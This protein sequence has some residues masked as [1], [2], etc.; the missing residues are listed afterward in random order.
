MVVKIVSG[1]VLAGGLILLLFFGGIFN[2][3]SDK[4][5]DVGVTSEM[6]DVQPNKTAKIVKAEPKI[7]TADAKSASSAASQGIKGENSDDLGG[8]AKDSDGRCKT[9]E[10]LE[11]ILT[12]C[13][14]VHN[15]VHFI[16]E[17]IEFMRIQGVDRFVLY[18]DQS[19]DGLSSL[20]EFYQQRDPELDLHVLPLASDGK[21]HKSHSINLQD[22]LTTFRNSTEWII[23]SD[24][25]EFIFSPA[26]KSLRA[27]LQDIP[28]MEQAK[29]TTVQHIHVSCSRFGAMGQ[30]NRA[31]YRLE[32]Q[33]DGTILYRNGCGE[34]LLI[35][36]VRRAPTRTV[37]ERELYDRMQA[38]SACTTT[39][40][41]NGILGCTQHLGKTIFRP[42]H[43]K[44]VR[45]SCA[46][47]LGEPLFYPLF[48]LSLLSLSLFACSLSLSLSLSLSARDGGPSLRRSHHVVRA[49]RLDPA[50]LLVRAVRVGSLRPP[51]RV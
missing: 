19:T 31:E 32:R 1:V 35:N 47:R 5:T 14:T 30:R 12:L 48:A 15:S 17:W 40:K 24:A 13:T 4:A 43:V 39:A 3:V 6:V 44:E 38:S 37:H 29:N 7:S 10:K 18:D 49:Q 2:P 42:R 27:M 34:Q 22:C 11:K 8:C 23:N 50:R 33:G 21:N 20:V 51:P 28:R 46:C 26:Y 16:V 9:K 36:K 25:D 45:R 41:R